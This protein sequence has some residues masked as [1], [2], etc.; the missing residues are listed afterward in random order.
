MLQKLNEQSVPMKFGV[1]LIVALVLGGLGYYFTMDTVAANTEKQVA[2]DKMK[3]DNQKLKE[4][5][6]RLGDLEKRIA[7]FRQQMVVQKLILPDE[8]EADNLITIL[9]DTASQAGVQIRKL[10]AKAN[11][12]KEYYTEAPFALQLDGPF[13]G[14]R[15]FFDKLASQ[16]R[17]IN[18][19]GLDMKSLKQNASFAY[20]PNDSVAVLCTT[21]TFYGKEFVAPKAEEPKDKKAKK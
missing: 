11:S 15:N 12:S 19:E 9:Q 13:Y 1:A 10:E 6:T 14:M 20:G 7:G 17:I 3:A 21:K 8:K 5:E 2:I 4:F 18:V 16:T